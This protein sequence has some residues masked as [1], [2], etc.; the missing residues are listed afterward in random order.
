MFL[1]LVLLSFDPKNLGLTLEFFDFLI[2]QIQ[3]HYSILL[4][5]LSKILTINV[6]NHSPQSILHFDLTGNL[7][8]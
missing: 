2:S 8:L 3:T 6:L 7:T 4:T 5:G 1:P